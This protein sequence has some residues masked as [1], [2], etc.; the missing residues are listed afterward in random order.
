MTGDETRFA[1]LERKKGGKVTLGDNTQCQVLGSGSIY[2]SNCFSIEKV[3]LVDG[4]KHN[5]LS[6]SQLCDKGFIVCFHNNK[7][8][9][10]LKNDISLEGF[11]VDNIYKINLDR[12]DTKTEICLKTTLDESWLW[13]RRLCHASMHTLR[14]ITRGRLVRGVPSLDFSE[15]HLCDACQQ[16]KLTRVSFHST[17]LTATSEP[18]E[19]LHMDLFG[20]ISTVSLGGKSYGFVIVDDFTRFTWVRVLRAKS[21]A[22]SEFKIF[23]VW[24]QRKTGKLIRTIHSDH[25]GEFKNSDFR[26]MCEELG[27]EHN[28]SVPRTPQQ[29][30][31]AERKNRTLIE[32]ARSI[33]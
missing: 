23:C 14:K 32:A 18:L 30:G 20:P 11:R 7:C 22:F 2:V 29:N 15:D 19:I 8:T 12:V 28:F 16:G 9:L 24:I 27:I 5:L 26:E 17:P 10:T 13:H 4:L 1:T 6:V 33:I 31:V 25:G 21:D 3:L